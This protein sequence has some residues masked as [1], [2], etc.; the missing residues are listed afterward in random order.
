[1]HSA[2]I[3]SVMS[4]YFAGKGFDLAVFINFTTLDVSADIHLTPKIRELAGNK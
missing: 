3:M 4:A 2:R 1:M